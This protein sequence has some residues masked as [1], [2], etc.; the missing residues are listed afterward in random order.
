[1]FLLC[2]R[3]QLL[4]ARQ[5]E[6]R[7]GLV[8]PKG[9]VKPIKAELSVKKAMAALGVLSRAGKPWAHWEGEI[10]KLV[11]VEKAAAAALAAAPQPEPKPEPAAAGGDDMD[12]EDGF[13]Q[14][15]TLE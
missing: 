12:Q 15:Q 9:V 8:K 14:S 10:K 3:L 7:L 13:Q 2:L 11:E 5:T 6:K 1:M 4:F